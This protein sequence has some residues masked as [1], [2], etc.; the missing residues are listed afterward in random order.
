MLYAN[1]QVVDKTS[2]GFL[3]KN[4]IQALAA[5]LLSFAIDA[6]AA[7]IYEQL[8]GNS[9]NRTS[10][11]LD[12]FGNSPGFRAA[13]DFV[14][15]ADASISDV[16]W[17]GVSLSGG[18]DFQFTFYSDDGGKPGAVLHTSDGSLSTEVTANHGPF[19]SSDL[20]SSF[21]AS[22]GTRYWISI[23]NEAD[24]AAWAW[25]AAGD[26]GNLSRQG[27]NPGA[28]WE[29]EFS[30]LAFQLTSIPEPASLALF[31]IG[32]AGLGFSRRRRSLN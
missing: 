14:L 1:F 7:V 16:H 13:D 20:T 23:F 9:G 19:Y 28:P 30:D 12:F 29:L 18:I 8:P 11:T 26:P 3:V 10:S 25:R 32:L 4:L 5:F 21:S 6:G 22:A 24:D 31:A 27:V 2:R 17:W 15:S